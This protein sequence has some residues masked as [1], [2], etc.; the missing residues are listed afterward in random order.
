MG[1]GRV[2]LLLPMSFTTAL[3]YAK[4]LKKDVLRT[5]NLYE[6]ATARK[7]QVSFLLGIVS[8]IAS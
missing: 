7:L 8:S 1:L 3:V 4:T 6:P 5:S 2:G